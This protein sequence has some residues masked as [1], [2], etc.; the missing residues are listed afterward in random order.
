MAYFADTTL[1]SVVT[2]CLWP[3]GF[4]FA[5]IGI[6]AFETL[7]GITTFLFFSFFHCFIFVLGYTPKLKIN[8]IR[9]ILIP[10]AHILREIQGVW[11]Y[12]VGF[13][14]IPIVFRENYQLDSRSLTL[15]KNKFRCFQNEIINPSAMFM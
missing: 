5:L 11:V 4:S 9:G 10:L 7:I 12:L 14:I 3:Y 6:Y 2:F 15:R 13:E 1:Y 8:I